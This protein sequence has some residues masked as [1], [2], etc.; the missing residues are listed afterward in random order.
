ARLDHDANSAPLCFGLNQLEYVF[1]D[2]SNVVLGS[3]WFSFS[4]IVQKHLHDAGDAVDLAQNYLQPFA[5]LLNVGV[6]E[7]EFCACSYHGHRS[8][9]LVRETR[10]KGSYGG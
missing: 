1:N 3:N 9:D 6:F 4:S 2:R 5:S 8:A 10:G 7:Q